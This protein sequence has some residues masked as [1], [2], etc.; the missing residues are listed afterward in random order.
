M[1]TSASLVANLANMRTAFR[2]QLAY[3][4]EYRWGN[5][6]RTTISKKSIL[7]L[8][9]RLYSKF[10]VPNDIEKDGNIAIFRQYNKMMVL[11]IVVLRL[12]VHYDAERLLHY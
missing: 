8:I 1:E 5:S 4:Y 12:R 6:N 11:E 7:W 3:G 2:H 9:E 10:H